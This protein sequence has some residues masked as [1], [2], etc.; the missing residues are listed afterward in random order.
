MR[1]HDNCDQNLPER[2]FLNNIIAGLDIKDK[3]RLQVLSDI[4]FQL[5]DL[6]PER[7]RLM[8]DL[9]QDMKKLP[10]FVLKEE[11]RLQHIK[12]RRGPKFQATLTK[13]DAKALKASRGSTEVLANIAN[14]NDK[15]YSSEWFYRLVVNLAEADD[16]VGDQ[17]REKQLAA[18][19]VFIESMRL[20]KKK[21]G[22][23]EHVFRRCKYDNRFM[24][25][26]MLLLNASDAIVEVVIKSLGRKR[27]H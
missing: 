4:M 6:G 17:S 14:F 12:T 1:S 16:L 27:R 22:Q 26:V 15:F 8:L 13:V 2:Y 25:A 10:L 23:M 24:R 19:D 5:N 9:L 18:C 3:K 7:L 21:L 20:T 11:S